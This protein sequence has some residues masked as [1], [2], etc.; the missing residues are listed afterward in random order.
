MSNKRL[1][2]EEPI[3]LDA[4]LNLRGDHARYIGR[5]LRLR[6]DDALTVFDGKGNEFLVTIRS[7]RKSVI[8]T[9]VIEA[10]DRT[11]ESPLKVTLI[12]GVS[13]GDRMD[14][15]I[16]KATELGV[17]RVVPVLTDYSVV[18]LDT[19]RAEKKQTHWEGVAVSAC[20]QCGRNVLPMIDA[21][22]PL[23]DVLADYHGTLSTRILLK[24]GATKTLKSLDIDGNDVTLL[25]GPEGGFSDLEY[26]NAEV[27]GFVPVGFG[28]RIL[29]TETAALT[30]LA[31]LQS[32]YGDLS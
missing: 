30:A 31:A 23:V 16:Q 32:L 21:P 19:N 6:P 27:A 18:K 17:T 15:A 11:S 2:V 25:V 26:E 4:D 5:V 22:T 8:E 10:L 12:Q 14:F 28:P 9:T 29:R 7:I 3:K 24:P 1:Y 20:E 13:K